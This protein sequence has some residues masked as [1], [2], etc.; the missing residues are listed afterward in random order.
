M[1]LYYYKLPDGVKNFGDELNPWLWQKLL[2][3]VMDDDDRQ[4]FVGIGTLIN[5]GMVRRTAKAQQRII[6]GTGVGYGKAIPTVD[7]TFKIYCLRGPLSAK[8][9]EVPAELA[10]TDG[11]FLIRQAFSFGGPK[12]VKFTYMPHY[13]LAGKGWERVCQ[14]LGFGYIDPRWPVETVLQAI[15]QTEVLLTEAMH[16]AIIADAFRVPWIPVVTNASIL[17]FKWQDWCASLQLDYQPNPI[18]RLHHP[19]EQ[20]DSLAALRTIRDRWR[21]ATAATNLK[22]VATTVRPLLSSDARCEQ[23]SQRLLETLETFKQDWKTGRLE[24]EEDDHKA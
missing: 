15:D 13:E 12:T 14:R 22:R 19:R 16:G 11:A 7:P 10:I 5:D 20:V 6:F 2:P 21:Q 4:I 9:L 3:G 18:D 24:Q 1:K 23:A 17:P 8:A